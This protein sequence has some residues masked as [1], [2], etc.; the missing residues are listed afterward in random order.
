MTDVPPKIATIICPYYMTKPNRTKLRECYIEPFLDMGDGIRYNGNGRENAEVLQTKV[1]A[2]KIVTYTSQKNLQHHISV[3]PLASPDV[4]ERAKQIAINVVGEK[5]FN[6]MAQRDQNLLLDSVHSIYGYGSTPSSII[7]IYT[8][9]HTH[10]EFDKYLYHRAIAIAKASGIRLVF[11]DAVS[12]KEV[13][14]DN[15]SKITESKSS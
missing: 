9:K 11:I 14:H 8:G 6:K 1:N 12:K 2:D 13:K 4:I 7:F 10:H 15:S 5:E 3:A